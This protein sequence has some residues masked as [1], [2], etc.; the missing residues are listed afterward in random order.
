VKRGLVL[1]CV[2]IL[3]TMLQ[4]AVAT[5]IPPALVPDLGLLLVFGIALCWRSS[6]GGLVL[7]AALGYVADLLSGTLLGEHALMRVLAFGA[8]RFGSRH[9]NLRGALPQMAFV[10]GLTAVHA[11]LLGTLT[12]FMAGAVGASSIGIWDLIAHALV[13]A[14][15]APLVAALTG[16][17]LGRLG[18]DEAGRRLLSLE[19]RSWSS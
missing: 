6:A 12:S 13:N 18:D 7:S 14:L 1:L 2:G 16:L 3:A 15:F 8:A 9:L 10:A 4:G 19:P 5:F 11:L 17:L